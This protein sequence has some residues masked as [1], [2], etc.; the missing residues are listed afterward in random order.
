MAVILWALVPILVVH[1][2][3]WL[4]NRGA[5]RFQLLLDIILLVLFGPALS[6]GLVLDPVRCLQT[7]PPFAAWHW[8][9]DTTLQPTQSD[10]VLQFHPWWEEARRQI[11]RGHL[12]LLAPH[13]GGGVPLLAQGQTGFFAPVMAPVW[14]L[15]PE[16]GT[17]V[18]A[19]WKIEAAALGTFL[20]LTVA[21][22]LR[23]WAA[24]VGALAYG[25]GP[26]M[27]AWLLVPL[28]WSVA[29]VPWLWWLLSWVLRGRFRL[30][31]P[32]A[33]LLCG[34]L[35]GAGL[36]PES[37]TIVVGSALLAGLVLHPRRWRRLAVVG[38]ISLATAVVLA[39][40]TLRTI[41][42][43]SKASAYRATNPNLAPLPWS[44]R[45]A[46]LEQMLLPAVHGHP[47][48]GT[49]HGP[50][51]YAAGA[52]GIGGA[53]LA[54]IVAGGVRRR[55][56]RLLAAA[57]AALGV[58]A[59]LAFRLPP[60][61]LLLV[62]LPPFDRMTLPRFGL[63]VPWGLSLWAA[64]AAHGGAAGTLRR[65]LAWL[66]PA[67]LIVAALAACRGWG[68]WDLALALVAG[69]AA[70]AALLLLSPRPRWLAAVVTV[71]LVLLAIGIN[72]TAAPADQ[73]PRPPVLAR[74]QERCK[75]EPGRIIGLGEV[76]PPNVAVRYGLADLR[77]FDPL[78]P[79][80][81]ARLHA[82]LGADNPVL[83]GPVRSAPPHLLGAWSV[84]Y[85]LTLPD[86]AAPGWEAV[87]QGDGIRV[88]RNP[89]WQPEVRL[90]GR[91]VELPEEA[92][93][94]LLADDPAVLT[95]GVVVAAGTEL[96]SASERRLEVLDRRPDRLVARVT[97]N[98]PC[99]LVLAQ[100]WAPGWRARVDGV[101]RPVVRADL[102]GLGVVC[103]PGRHEAVL[104]YRPW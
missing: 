61:D 62:R 88:W 31:T 83:P 9:P 43:S 94:N 1:A 82:L 51:P 22:R 36:H 95:D 28:A 63:L 71:E 56:R 48:R 4:R 68:G 15:G 96:V 104:A 16:R 99:L 69:V 80:P 19:V 75:A 65:R 74:L 11:I 100:P 41:A 2:V 40:P 89:F 38:A 39:W 92:G 23:S 46:A 17:T 21:W 103:P 35:V 67:G 33:G 12:P 26:F 7:S 45:R 79:W 76:L 70:A 32:V 49:W 52:L 93:W 25:A 3:L 6:R 5:L 64:A 84:R 98:G 29:A 10:V 86:A 34:W 60:L 97:C 27:M 91:T 77:S 14:A 87:D 102:A 24:A 90:A 42:A 78:R 47:G 66:L 72:P 54:L 44:L 85:L 73:T 58:A 37:A 13:I 55:H 57:L 30:R 53:A 59:V 18:M 20:L 50:Y 101:R 81:L 8:S